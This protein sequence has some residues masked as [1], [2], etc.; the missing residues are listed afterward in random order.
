MGFLLLGV[1]SLIAGDS[2]ASHGASQRDRR[3]RP[4]RRSQDPAGR[5]LTPIYPSPRPRHFPA[6]AW[7]LSTVIPEFADEQERCPGVTRSIPTHE[8]ALYSLPVPDGNCYPPFSAALYSRYKYGSLTATETFARALSAALD[9][10]HPD[11]IRVPRLVMTSSPYSHVPTAATTLARELRPVLNA[12]R[13]RYGLAPVP[14]IH[15]YRASTSA[16]DYGTLAAG[17]RD[18]RM[19]A[20]VLS[21]RRFPLAEVRDAHL[22]VVDDVRVTGAHQRN[23]TH[24]SDE[25]PLAARTFLYIASFAGPANG[26]FDPTQEDALNH[27]S[28]RTLDDLARIV[29]DDDF[30]GNVRV[31]KFALNPA[32]RPDLP[33]FLARMPDRFV[34]D[35][36][37]GS[38]R[39]GYARMDLYAPSH[40]IVGA[41]LERRR[42]RLTSDSLSSRRQPV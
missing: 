21:F 19:T 23:L 13:A 39:D 4:D 29:E 34:R 17:A 5:R 30:A 25:L 18:Q 9:D 37:R 3:S 1:D 16:G 7:L 2:P 27:A 14:L 36:H 31:C 11:L 35:L 38:Q 8:F 22:L 15:V 41:E 32:N 33:K 40:A 6:A 20:N 26:Y 12:A 42:G 10:R 28:I 24:A